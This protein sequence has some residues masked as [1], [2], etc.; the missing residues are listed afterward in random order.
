MAYLEI[1]TGRNTIIFKFLEEWIDKNIIT[2][3]IY[4]YID[5]YNYQI[6][7]S[8]I[9]KIKNKN[10]MIKFP[11]KGGWK[12]TLILGISFYTLKLK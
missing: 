7:Q 1:Q 3:L 5:T 4:I 9:K 8:W 11:F 10:N 12:P 2:V 6:K